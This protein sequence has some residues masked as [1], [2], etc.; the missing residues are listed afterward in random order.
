MNIFI[1]MLLLM[2][3]LGAN[4]QTIQMQKENTSSESLRKLINQAEIDMLPNLAA[5][6]IDSRE[7]RVV[8]RISTNLKASVTDE[9]NAFIEEKGL[10]FFNENIESGYL[11]FLAMLV[12]KDNEYFAKTS[13]LTYMPNPEVY[14][15]YQIELKLIELAFEKKYLGYLN[16]F[17]CRGKYY[18]AVKHDS[19]DVYKEENGELI[20]VYSG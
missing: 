15:R 12:N 5:K 4:S 20:F 13:Y 14:T 7:T 10:N 18:I 8:L 11:D 1:T 16:L 6:G 17:G 9:C 19:V 3:S 2:V